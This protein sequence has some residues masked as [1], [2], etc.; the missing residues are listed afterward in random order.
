MTHLEMWT[1]PESRRLLFRL[2]GHVVWTG[3]CLLSTSCVAGPPPRA[4]APRSGVCGGW[5]TP[6]RG[7]GAGTGCS[8]TRGRSEGQRTW[9]TLCH[10]PGRPP[11]SPPC[12]R[13]SEQWLS[14]T[15]PLPPPPEKQD[16]KKFQIKN[17]PSNSTVGYSKEK[18]NK[19][20]C[21]P[22]LWF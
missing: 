11:T 1:C 10:L 13:I 18:K 9:A 14:P 2:F 20:Q 19:N 5:Y 17:Q 22:G 3:R 6:Q 16:L 12:G 15:A 4:P 8:R 21:Q 7:L